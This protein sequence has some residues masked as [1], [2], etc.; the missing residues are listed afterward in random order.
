MRIVILGVK[1]MLGQALKHVLRDYTLIE[2]DR[3]ELD[4]TSKEDID[5]SISQTKPDIVINAAAYNDVDGAEREPEKA[6][7]L[8]ATAVE[9][10]A[11]AAQNV[12]ALLIHYSTDYV[13]FG[14]K[15]EGY[16]ETD[17]PEPIS[18]YGVS[19][20]KG[21]QA[22]QT[23]AKR[24]Y[25]IRTSRLFGP[26]ATSPLAKKSF[27]SK[28]IDLSK[29]Q[30]ILEV[31]DEEVS[32]PTYV[33]DL[34]TRTREVI[35]STM[36]FG[37]YHITNTGGCTWFQFSQEI[38]QTL[39]IRATLRAVPGSHFQRLAKRPMYSMLLN[40]K[41]PPMRPWQAAL[42]EFLITNTH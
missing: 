28:M 31:I 9:F 15:K 37:V 42:H 16:A 1:G 3:N 41:L 26:E 30:S 7:L 24:Y 22:V 36:P 40:T 23:N 4:V 29:K 8:N 11:N 19:K 17:R 6:T 35:E 13:F 25:L 14:D 34:A 32:S 39:K 27:V 5:R 18:A 12:G 21:E 2:Y 38:F 10:L 20:L 33:L